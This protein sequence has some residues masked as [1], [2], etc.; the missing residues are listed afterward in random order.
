M[1]TLTHFGWMII[2]FCFL[3]S[4]DKDDDASSD[5]GFYDGAQS[6]AS[7]NALKGVWSI[8]K[9]GFDGNMADVPTNYQECGRDFFSFGENSQYSDYIFKSSF[10]DY[11][12]NNLNWEL[13]NGVISFR[14]QSHQSDEWVVTDLNE[15]DLTFKAQIDVDEDGT[16]DIITLYAKRYQPPVIDLVTETF[17]PNYDEAFQN[18]ISYKWQ[19]YLGVQQFV[20]YE[21][22]RSVGENCTKEN[23]VLV[24][25]ITDPRITE[26][27]DLMPPVEEYLCYYLKTT[28]NSGTLGESRLFPFNTNTLS[29]QFVNLYQPEV[30]NA[31]ISLKWEQSKMPYFSHYEIAY[32]NYPAN[33]TASGEQEVVVTKISDIAVTSFVDENLPYLENPI[34]KIFV[35]DIFGHKSL[36]TTAASREVK[37]KRAELLDIYKLFSYAIDPTEP[38]VYFYGYE[39]KGANVVKIHR[40]NYET[41]QTEAIS[42]ASPFIMTGLSL[43]IITSAHGNELLLEQ[44]RKLQVYNAQTLMHKYDLEA[45]DVL[46]FNDFLYTSAGFWVFTDQNFIYTYTRNE[47]QLTLVDKKPHFAGH[48]P[49]YNY[50]VFE[51]GNNQLILGHM[52][53]PNSMVFSIAAN[54]VLTN[55]RT[56]AVPIKEYDVRKSQ[57]NAA[58]KYIINFDD[59]RL[60]STVNFAPLQAFQQ[61][62]FATGISKDGTQIF[63]SNNDPKWDITPESQHAK[64]VVIFNR[65][66]Q[67]TFKIATKGY[68]H[69]VFESYNGKIMSI[70]SGIKRENLRR[71]D[72]GKV[73]LFIET[74]K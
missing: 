8:Y 9:V 24:K 41:N 67:Q 33:V 11:D 35:Y 18:L 58:G 64:E 70:S 69:V 60:Y 65:T 62:N 57:Y 59:N 39:T 50:S 74:V 23:A 22:Y 15:N 12:I 56:V 34:Y 14:N 7:A 27:T 31:T 26:F 71:N 43:K 16:L 44:G 48:Q 13:K 45:S 53:E 38:I 29:A 72:D 54:G 68:P 30:I 25:T 10:C 46:L 19:P 37:Y 49:M 4:C 2:A 5:S 21:I 28:I 32:S 47:S 55:T 17:T 3:V 63:G 6:S 36:A 40:Y 52:Y 61:P 66:T 73:D 1:K 42:S 20:S 51:I